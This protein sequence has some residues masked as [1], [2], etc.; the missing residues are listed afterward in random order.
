MLLSP[1]S[2]STVLRSFL[3]TS[4]RAQGKASVTIDPM[5]QKSTVYISSVGFETLLLLLD[6]LS[7]TDLLLATTYQRLFS[8]ARSPPRTDYPATSQTV[9]TRPSPP[10]RQSS[11]HSFWPMS[12][13]T[14]TVSE[15]IMAV[16][17]PVITCE[18]CESPL[19]T[20]DSDTCMGG[21]DGGEVDGAEYAC[22]SCSRRV[23]GTC[24]VVE[25]GEGRECLQCRTSTR[26]KW[27]GGIGWML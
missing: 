26:K 9:H 2:P 15:H 12:S 16:P 14:P 21:M 4:I 24:A 18:D 7:L 19:P 5:I 11:L 1:R 22:R 25:I 20:R 17:S 10:Q 13:S 27:V 23:C 8:A 6:S 3:L